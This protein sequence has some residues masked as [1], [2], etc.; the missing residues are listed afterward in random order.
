V[1][2][3]VSVDIANESGETVAAMTVHWHVKRTG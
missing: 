3:P 1:E 2:F